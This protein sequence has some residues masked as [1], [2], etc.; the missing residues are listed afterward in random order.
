MLVEIK[1]SNASQPCSPI[2]IPADTS[3][4]IRFARG[5][6]R[7][8]WHRLCS[9]SVGKE[10]GFTDHAWKIM[11]L[12]NFSPDFFGPVSEYAVKNPAAQLEGLDRYQADNPPVPGAGTF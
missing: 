6:I 11:Q 4:G 12:G 1:S 5:R 2:H 3:G 9:Q 8:Y 10:F 7:P